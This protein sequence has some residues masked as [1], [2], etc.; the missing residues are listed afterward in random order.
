MSLQLYFVNAFLR[1]TFKRRFRKNP[2]LMELRAILQR[3]PVMRVP[4]RIRVEQT[5][6][7]GVPT[8]KLSAAGASSAHALLYIHGGGFVGG[9]PATHRQLT[10]RLAE[11]THVPVYAIDYRLAPE[12]PFP[13]ALDDC[14]AAYRALLDKG[15]AARAIAVGGDSAG[16]NLTLALALKLKALGLP[17]PAALVCLSPVTDLAAAAPTQRMN[18]K[19]DAMFDPRTFDTVGKSY[20]PGHDLTDPLISPRRGD[21]TG[22]PPTLFHASGAEMLRDDSILMAEK[23]RAAGVDVTIEIWPKVA[24]VWHVTSDLLPEGRAAIAKIALFLRPRLAMPA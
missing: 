19:S 14:V 11:E 15:L 6:L 21:V 4:R 24:H 22:L 13:A 16:G 20:C 17:E 5:S 7:G 23:M 12:H 1:F 8:E 9:S 10:W 18:E 2:D 3:M